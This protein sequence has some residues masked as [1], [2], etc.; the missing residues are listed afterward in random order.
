MM[1]RIELESELER[2]RDALREALDIASRAHRGEEEW[3]RIAAI[4]KEHD[5]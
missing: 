2:T 4:R 5:L 3:N 1:S